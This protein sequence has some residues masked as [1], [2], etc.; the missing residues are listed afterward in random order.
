MFLSENIKQGNLTLTNF[1]WDG[2]ILEICAVEAMNP[3]ATIIL[4]TNSDAGETSN[5]GCLNSNDTKCALFNAT[6]NPFSTLQQ[7]YKL[8][9][10]NGTNQNVGSANFS[11]NSTYMLLYA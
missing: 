3:D 11:V 1:D 10:L 5:N 7:T 4:L 9:T 2:D 8:V 6:E